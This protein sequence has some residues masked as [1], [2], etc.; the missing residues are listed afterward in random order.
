MYTKHPHTHTLP[1]PHTH[2]HMHSNAQAF[3]VGLSSV[4]SRHKAYIYLH[5]ARLLGYS[6]RQAAATTALYKRALEE[7]PDNKNVWTA[8][9]HHEVECGDGV[10]AVYIHTTLYMYICVYV[11]TINNHQ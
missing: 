8:A 10:Y 3:E 7:C 5:Y 4:E 6:L 2:I 1:H 9:V 11:I